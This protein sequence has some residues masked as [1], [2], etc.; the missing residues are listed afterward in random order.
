LKALDQTAREAGGRIVAALA[1]TFRDLDLAEEAFAEA[2]A[3]AAAVWPAA[4]PLDPPP[5]STPPRGAARWI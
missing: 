4:P 3:R 1:A 5:G 2:C